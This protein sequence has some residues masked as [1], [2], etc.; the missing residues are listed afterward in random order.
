M[1]THA[2][3]ESR[4]GPP[5]VTALSVARPA[6]DAPLTVGLAAI[7][8]AIAFAAD[9]GLQIGR[10]TPVEMG[11]ILGGGLAVAGAV[12]VAPRRERL[13]GAGTLALLIALAALTA[14]SIVW[15]AQP[16]DA[17]LE[18]NRTLAYASVFAAAVGL[19]HALPGRWSAVLGGVTLAA[20]AISAYAL[21]TKVFPGALNP[22]EVYA[23]LREPFDYWNAVGLMAA[24]GVPGCLWL[25][26]RRAS[27][28]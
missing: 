4:P 3:L 21:L 1:S 20:V 16:A 15:A 8:C 28:T 27:T 14:L 13:W 23:R 5:A 12:L 22:D 7:L 11:L 25:G 2:A 10:T 17:W 18:A 9:G 19:A 24:L 26:A 6:G